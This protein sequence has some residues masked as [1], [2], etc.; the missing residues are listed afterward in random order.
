MK[1]VTAN[2]LKNL[3]N[4]EKCKLMQDIIK[5]KIKYAGGNNG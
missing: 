4:I 3:N 1:T 5:G 2:E